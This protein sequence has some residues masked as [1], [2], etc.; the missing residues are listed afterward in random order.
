[1]R[2]LYND[3]NQSVEIDVFY[4]RIHKHT[5]TLEPNERTEI[6]K[7]GHYRN[8]KSCDDEIFIYDGKGDLPLSLTLKGYDFSI[9]DPHALETYLL[10]DTL[11]KKHK[12]SYIDFKTLSELNLEKGAS[13]TL[14]LITP[15][16]YNELW[17]YIT[18]TIHKEQKW[19]S[20][21]L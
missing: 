3:T 12:Q 7:S 15:P 19:A 18:N 5:I 9:I 16:R 6:H 1:M 8:F 13:T 17:S 14:D 11:P 21:R 20:I 4:S 10:T 2:I